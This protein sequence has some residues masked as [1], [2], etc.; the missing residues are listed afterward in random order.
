MACMLSVPVLRT[1][2]IASVH[3]CRYRFGALAGG[4]TQPEPS[5]AVLVQQLAACAAAVDGLFEGEAR[6]C[7]AGLV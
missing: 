2:L 1:A 3:P 5:L 6:G 7:C 4:G